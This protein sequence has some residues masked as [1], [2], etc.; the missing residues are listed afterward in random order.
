VS[1]P[2]PLTGSDPRVLEFLQ[3]LFSEE[4]HQI[5]YTI[6]VAPLV[7]IPADDFDRVAHHLRQRR[8]DDRGARIALEVARN[9]FGSLVAENALQLTVGGLLERRIDCLNSNRLLGDEGEVDDGDVRRWDANGEAVEPETMPNSSC[10]TLTTGARQLVVQEALEMMLCLAGSYFDSLTP[11]TTVMS[12]LVAGAEMMTFFTDPCRWALALVASVKMPVDST[13]I[14]APVEVQSSL[15]GSLSAKTLIDLP[16]TVIESAEEEI[17]FFRLPRIESYL[18]RCASVAGLVRSLTATISMSGL[19]SAARKTLRP[20]RP[21]PLIPTF[22]A[23]VKTF[24]FVSS[25]NLKSGVS[26]CIG[27]PAASVA[28]VANPHLPMLAPQSIARHKNFL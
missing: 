21:K 18:S 15:A 11:R 19:P 13:M 28:K 22:T 27:G 12:S 17:S 2:D 16:S 4:E 20:M 6:R 24:S 25:L 23:I 1:G 8:V 5:A 26:P 7:V 10:S 14:C 3:A 9:Q